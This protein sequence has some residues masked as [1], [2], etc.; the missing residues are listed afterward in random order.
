MDVN[1]FGVQALTN[2]ALPIIPTD[3]SGFICIVSSEVGSWAHFH[4]PGEVRARLDNFDSLEVSEV[5]QYVNEYIAST[6]QGRPGADRFPPL[7]AAY[8]PYGSSKMFVS[9]YGRILARHLKDKKIPV[10]LVCVQF[11]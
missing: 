5:D 7:E 1:Y 3:G 8:G 11:S 2:A 4:C 6:G 9:T 10:S